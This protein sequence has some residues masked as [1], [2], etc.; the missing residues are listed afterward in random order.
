MNLEDARELVAAVADEYPAAYQLAKVVSL[1]VRIELELLRKA[2][3]ELLPPEVD[4]GAEADLLFSSLVQSQSPLAM[5]FE[6]AVTEVLREHLAADQTL[7]EATWKLLD[8]F[9]Q[10]APP[11]LRLEEE[12]TWLALAG[13]N[14]GDLIQKRLESVVVAMARDNRPGLAKWAIRALP[15]MPKMA[16]DS[17][18][19]RILSLVASAP[20]PAVSLSMPSATGSSGVNEWLSQ[21]ISHNLPKVAV[22]VRLLTQPAADASPV[23]APDEFEEIVPPAGQTSI[24]VEF[25]YPPAT[26]LGLENTIDAPQTNPVL[27]E[28]SWPAEPEPR[29][30][31][32]S[33]QP[34]ET[35]QIEVGS[36]QLTIR[37]ALG[38]VHTLRPRFDYDFYLHYN[39]SDYD[40][41]EPLPR[42]FAQ[43][44]EGQSLKLY[45]P[46]HDEQVYDRDPL[47]YEPQFR[48]SRKVGFVLN[49]DTLTDDW[50]DL[51]AL[52]HKRA[53]FQRMSDWLIPIFK[54][55]FEVRLPSF[56]LAL[57]PI[58]FS[59]GAKNSYQQLL[60][61]ITGKPLVAGQPETKVEPQETPAVVTT[62]PAD[63][64]DKPLEVFISYAHE[65]RKL[66]DELF[67]H[68]TV[69][70]QL[71]LINIWD[72]SDESTPGIRH[73]R[74]VKKRLERADI[75]LLLISSNYLNTTL[76]R[77]FEMEPAL[78]RHSN[79]QARVIPILVGPIAEGQSTF[80]NIQ[81]IP[82]NLRPINSWA[83]RE[84][85]Y[86]EVMQDLRVAIDAALAERS[87]VEPPPDK[88]ITLPASVPSPPDTGF[89]AR[90][91]EK[92]K[93]IVELLKE[94]LKPRMSTTSAVVALTGPG[95]AGKTTVAAETA[96]R[97][98]EVFRRRVVWINAT[99][100]NFTLSTLL[101]EIA[102][103][104]RSPN[105]R[106]LPLE[107]KEKEVSARTMEHPT[108]I[109]VDNFESVAVVARSSCLN[110]LSKKAR[111]SVL[112]NF[113]GPTPTARN[114]FLTGMSDEE[115]GHFLN[116]LLAQFSPA[117][118]RNPLE[119]NSLI[120]VADRNPLALRWL[121][122]QIERTDQSHVL[123]AVQR[124]A[125]DAVQRVFDN[126]FGSNYLTDD[127]EKTLLALS[128][129][130]PDAPRAGLDSVVGESETSPKPE[131]A[132]QATDLTHADSA[133]LGNSL[134][135][136][137][138][139]GLISETDSGQRFRLDGLALDLTKARL[140]NDKQNQKAF[141]KRFVSYF[142][143][144]ASSYE[145][146]G[147]ELT[148]AFDSER[149]NL[150]AAMAS[151]AGDWPMVVRFFETAV[152]DYLISQGYLDEAL[153]WCFAAVEAATNLNSPS[154]QA[155]AELK[156]AT[157]YKQLE[158]YSNLERYTRHA[159]SGFQNLKDDVNLSLAFEQIAW[160]EMQRN[161][162][163]RVTTCVRSSLDAYRRIG[164]RLAF[165]IT[166][167]KFGTTL[168]ARQQFEA[169]VKLYKEIETS[170]RKEN[171][172][173]GRAF[174]LYLLGRVTNL[175]GRRDE[176]MRLLQS[177]ENLYLEIGH[178]DASKPKD[179]RAEIEKQPSRS[180]VT[181]T[182]SA[183]KSRTT[184]AIAKTSRPSRTSPA[185]VSRAATK[186]RQA[187]AS[188]TIKTAPAKKRATKAQAA[189]TA[190]PKAHPVTPNAQKRRTTSAGSSTRPAKTSSVKYG[191]KT[192]SKSVPA[193]AAKPGRNNS[194]RF[195]KR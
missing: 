133:R 23:S 100:P 86:A 54:E 135:D 75:I 101:N 180:R 43:D 11:A 96:R 124:R 72:N 28:V 55:T 68:V 113:P 110:F 134:R 103:Q 181:K 80:S 163:Q 122:K 167:E 25:S 13:G 184:K 88:A 94:A 32:I 189:K 74:D 175:A 2:R 127:A 170:S 42:M 176:A 10:N 112:I 97:L 182:S 7:L 119:R 95:G 115:A 27:L 128:L 193:K 17:D 45:F 82:R 26:G 87:R 188:E 71:G 99:A 141:Q 114:V 31:R 83:N 69:L 161:N 120:Q 37:T 168:E 30:E 15:A 53:D 36:E 41:A 105:L 190:R 24:V 159:I 145:P 111:C 108:L 78:A 3:I 90:K 4:A 57:N 38:D 107:R 138:A 157:I 109:V 147:S 195:K 50:K 126:F 155:R 104:L 73:Q 143:D 51:M 183:L 121:V 165:E 47:E 8:K 160:A 20:E 151:A 79:S 142:A 158:D 106:A 29:V 125:G 153:V 9:H 33:L 66:V 52:A 191:R 70:K 18:M 64:P 118:S 44:P 117:A 1:A 139:L 65:D 92:G 59:L 131:T 35:R 129:F 19:A 91:G 16:R 5:T 12:V 56:L 171:D 34:Q 178:P 130:S 67:K 58:D 136:L 123:S 144:V 63:P 81:L 76:L 192:S 39:A 146:A 177:S 6:P 62:L 21:I 89:V 187:Q 137:I 173:V 132:S 174:S 140:T 22:G 60:S 164:N 40:W 148:T 172:Q 14:N 46:V 169:A 116:L 102:S 98:S 150:V 186:Q 185:K 194:L 61:R 162:W 93:D 156:L 48:L 152:T 149:Q 179:L 166:L 77:K 85:A 84:E 154:V 49:S